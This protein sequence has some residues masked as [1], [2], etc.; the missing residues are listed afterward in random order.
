MKST[1]GVADESYDVGDWFFL[2]VSCDRQV[3]MLQPQPCKGANFV[4]L[5]DDGIRN[6]FGG[7][8]FISPRVGNLVWDGQGSDGAVVA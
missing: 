1:V 3:D 8:W 5:V 4:G 6:S 7:R 2:K